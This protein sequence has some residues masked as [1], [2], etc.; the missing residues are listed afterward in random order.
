MIAE[1]ITLELP[2]PPTI[3]HYWKHTKQGRHYITDK[4]RAYQ[5]KVKE[6]CSGSVPFT[7]PVSVKVQVWLPDKRRRDLD[8]LWKVLLDSLVNA[9]I[10]ADD[11]WQA[12]PKQSIEA[13]GVMKGGKLVVRLR[14]IA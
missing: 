10:V 2:Y 14:E 1:E 8:N 4:G 12:M 7:K 13:M 3:N 11:C 5:S 9:K 6:V